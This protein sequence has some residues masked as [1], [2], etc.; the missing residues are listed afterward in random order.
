VDSAQQRDWPLFC[1]KVAMPLRQGVEGSD[2]PPGPDEKVIR[3]GSID[4]WFGSATVVLTCVGVGGW[5]WL[6][7]R[8]FLAPPALAAIHWGLLRWCIPAKGIKFKRL[9][10]VPGQASF[11][12]TLLAGMVVVP[13]AFLLI[14]WAALP[15]SELAFVAIAVAWFALVCFLGNRSQRLLRIR[16]Q[17]QAEDAVEQW[18]RGENARKRC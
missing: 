18:E 14:R 2:P 13:V 9:G 10:S 12:C 16:Q 8:Q 17:K 11:L 15:M 3:R 1:L 6:N 7:D 4:L 5:W